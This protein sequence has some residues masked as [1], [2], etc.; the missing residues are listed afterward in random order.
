MWEKLN[1]EYFLH[2]MEEE[3]SGG[4]FC[5]ITGCV[6]VIDDFTGKGEEKVSKWKKG[7][8]NFDIGGWW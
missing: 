5:R 3:E 6:G 2:L 7:F 4:F 1:A 8:S